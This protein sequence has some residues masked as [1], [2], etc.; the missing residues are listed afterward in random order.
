[1]PARTVALHPGPQSD[2]AAVWT[3]PA[4]GAVKLSG[5]LTDLDPNCGDGIAWELRHTPISGP[6]K[7]LAKGT[8]A[9]GKAGT[10]GR[11]A[12]LA[13]TVAA[14]DRLELVVQ[15]N[16]EYTC[17]TTGVVFTISAADR[18][19]EFAADWLANPPDGAAKAGEWSVEEFGGAKAYTGP[20]AHGAQEGGV[21]GSPHAGVHDV[22]VHIR[23]RYDRLG[24]PVPRRFPEVVR[25]ADPPAITSGSG[26]KELAEWLT[27][28]DH[29]LTARVIVNRVW[30]FHFGEGL[31][32]TPSNFGVLGEPPTHPELLDHLAAGFVRNGWSLKQ[33][34]RYILLSATYQ[35]SAAAD[36]ATRAADPDNRLWGRYPRRRLEAEAVRDSLLAVSGALD[37]TKPGG[38][39]TKDFN[40]PRRTLYQT[41]IRSDRT[42]FGPLF[43]AADPTAPVDKRTVSTVA[44]QALFLMNHPFVKDRAKGF[45]ARVLARG[46]DDAAKLG[47]AHRLAFGR[48]PT[49]EE[50]RLGL[51]FVTAEGG[52]PAAWEAWCHLLFQANEFITIE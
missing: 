37:L 20:A 52:T 13:A 46:G 6:A 22:K 25:V 48:P 7:V 47:Y 49:D 29:P 28:P 21:P 16:A 11:P 15:R 5:A 8:V 12:P 17:D 26:R 45:A 34:H 51:E 50:K 19:W 14:G 9:N 30:Q 31:V 41:T 4:A 23:G 33:L 18:S 44:P 1:M 42:G 32:R 39:A 38:P 40:S 3:S 2:V 10:F 43:D 35:Q 27:R 24:E 36:P